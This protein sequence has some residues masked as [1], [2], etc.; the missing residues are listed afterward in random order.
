VKIK[1]VERSSLTLGSADVGYTNLLVHA[2]RC[3]RVIAGLCVACASGGIADGVVAALRTTTKSAGR[4]RTCAYD[5][6][7]RRSRRLVPAWVLHQR[8]LLRVIAGCPGR[9]AKAAERH[10]A[11]WGGPQAAASVFAA[12]ADPRGG[13]AAQSG[14]D[15]KLSADRL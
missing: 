6:C 1:I 5:E 11:R 12:V 3:R 13:R 7:A 10:V 14:R 2:G 4:R 8:L 9:G 15:L